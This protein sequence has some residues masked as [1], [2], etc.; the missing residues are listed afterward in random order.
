MDFAVGKFLPEEVVIDFKFDSCF[1]ISKHLHSYTFVE[2]D[3][4][5]VDHEAFK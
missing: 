4:F 3:Q 2:G 1:E 5:D